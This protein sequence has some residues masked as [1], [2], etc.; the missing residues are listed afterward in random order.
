MSKL[1]T[2]KCE[3][4]A[5]GFGNMIAANVIWIEPMSHNAVPSFLSTLVIDSRGMS[6]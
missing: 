5:A 3:L 6:L 1:N 2:D 4:L